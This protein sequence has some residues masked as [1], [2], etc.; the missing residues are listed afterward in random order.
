MG[1]WGL[2]NDNVWGFGVFGTPKFWVFGVFGTPKFGAFIGFLGGNVG[3][4]GGN[5][6]FLGGNAGFSGLFEARVG[7]WGGN[8]GFRV[9]MVC[10]SLEPLL[11][12]VEGSHGDGVDHGH[13][14]AV[15]LVDD[16]HVEVLQV[17]LD[18]LKV[19]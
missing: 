2:Q 13:F 10:H 12:G 5:V 17:E 6:G 4:L 16:D 19:D 7:F 9:G 14:A 18:P 3:F 8:V 15:V 1:F 11:Y